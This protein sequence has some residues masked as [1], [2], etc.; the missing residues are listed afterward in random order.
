LNPIVCI[1]VIVKEET[2]DM[3]MW[4]TDEDGT[5]VGKRFMF[6]KNENASVLKLYDGWKTQ[7]KSVIVD[8]QGKELEDYFHYLN[9]VM[10]I[11]FKG[12][13]TQKRRVQS[14]AYFSKGF[15]GWPHPMG[16]VMKRS[17]YWNDLQPY[18]TSHS[19]VLMI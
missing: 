10:H 9:N 17:S 2:G 11:P 12:G 7:K 4:A 8:M 5:Q 1:S 13:L 14:V 6:N 16:R 18:S 3:E 15:I 19:P